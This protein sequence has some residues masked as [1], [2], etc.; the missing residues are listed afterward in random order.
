MD[1]YDDEEI[2]PLPAPPR[3][4]G[5]PIGDGNFTGCAYGYGDI[6]PLT[7]PC[8]CPVCHGSGYE[9]VVG[10]F[11]PHADFGDPECCGCLNGVIRADHADIVCND[12]GAVVRTVPLN[13]LEKTLN[14]MELK[15]DLATAKCPHCQSVNLFPG[16]S[17]MLAF[18]C[19]TCGKGVSIPESPA[20]Q[21]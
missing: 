9:G 16:F 12:C 7:G 2:R 10:T 5:I 6:P 18:V 21:N 8:D 20:I 15:L 4:R 17:R 1:D 11:L 13:D 3:C 19:Q 14:E